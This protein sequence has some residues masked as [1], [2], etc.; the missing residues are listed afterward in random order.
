MLWNDINSGNFPE[1]LTRMLDLNMLQRLVVDA[2]PDHMFA[3]LVDLVWDS[4]SKAG[5]LLFIMMSRAKERESQD[6]SAD[7]DLE[8]PRDSDRPLEHTTNVTTSDMQQ[9]GKRKRTDDK[10]YVTR[11]KDFNRLVKKYKTHFTAKRKVRMGAYR[12]QKSHARK[13]KSE[14]RTLDSTIHSL[15]SNDE[16]LQR[17]ITS[18]SVDD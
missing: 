9:L 14:N 6:E 17:K 5:L 13:P 3:E 12:G 18:L 7:E 1:E 11:K 10:E 2:P 8:D 16:D 4:T 15:E